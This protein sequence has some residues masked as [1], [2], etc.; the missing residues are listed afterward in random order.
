MTSKDKSIIKP[1][2]PKKKIMVL[3][4]V[5]FPFFCLSGYLCDK[6]YWV[7]KCNKAI[8]SFYPCPLFIY[9]FF[10]NKKGT[11]VYQSHDENVKSFFFF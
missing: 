8:P 4:V 2:N 6:I 10:L 11:F 7:L 5:T 9:F 3:T 1:T